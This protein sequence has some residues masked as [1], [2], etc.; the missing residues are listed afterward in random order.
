[1][2]VPLVL[3]GCRDSLPHDALAIPAQADWVDHGSI[4]ARGGLGEWDLLQWGGFGGTAVKKNGVYYLYYQGARGYRSPDDPGA[5][6]RTIGVATSHDGIH[7]RKHRDNPVL[8]WFPN[9]GPEEGAVSAAALVDGDEIVV[10]YGANTEAGSA[11]YVH[12][13]ARL[14]TSNDG[15]AFRDRG[16]VLRRQDAELWGSGDEISPIVAFKEEGRWVVY[17]LPNGVPESRRLGV[18]WGSGRSALTRSTG[19]RSGWFGDIPLWGMGGAARVAPGFF[20]LFLNDVT[21]GKI[22]VRTVAIST[23]HRLSDP[24]HI[25][26]F[27]EASQATV[28]LDEDRRT[29]FLY[30]R[31]R[32]GWGV[33]VAPLGER[34]TTPPTR[35]TRLA[36]SALDDAGLE[37]SWE[38]ASDG[39]TG[40]A[41][42]EVYRDGQQIASVGEA[43]FVDSGLP[44]LTEYHY[45]VAAVNLHGTVGDRSSSV[46]LRSPADRTPPVLQSATS[47]GSPRRVVLVFDEPL[48]P[49]TAESV[50]SYAVSDGIRVESAVL[51]A[52]VRTVVLSTA[53]LAEGRRY[54]ITVRGVGDRSRATN[55]ISIPRKR[56]F[57]H[58]AVPGLVGVWRFE[59]AGG[60]SSP[61]LASYG[62]NAR[63]TNP[64]SAGPRRVVGQMGAA[65]E[66]DGVA[67]HVTIEPR[68]PLVRTT[69]GSHALTATVLPAAPDPESPRA[70]DRQSIVTRA[71][72]GIFY[73][74]DATFEAR[75]A[76]RDGE[77]ASLRSGPAP[78]GRPYDVTMTVDHARKLLRLYVDAREVPGSPVSYVGRLGD[79]ESQPYYLGTSNP[80]PNLA[81]YRFRGEIAEI[82]VYE[83]A[84]EPRAP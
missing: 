5:S 57:V 12:A 28:L 29:W 66:F 75:L 39:D 81:D 38:P 44:E 51:G 10:Y 76:L 45:Q 36:G 33:K 82:R 64:L 70:A 73:G 63:W 32:D 42:Y 43:R 6:R 27:P 79:S 80:I 40:V 62:S 30:Y 9:D 77:F 55:R 25:Y 65:L 11:V 14:A 48:E 71:G 83:G 56:A 24:V 17:Y 15:F 23:P 13:D 84:I 53:E 68:G 50:D 31:A 26:R 4:F 37:L 52:D 74:P 72:S 46:R 22:E 35:P 18:A 78:P 7:F 54:E 67:N 16:A 20:A 8:S 21:Q 60:E 19:A 41:S 59:A 47:S 34:D 58:S 2:L 3:L 69:L 49:A 61:D 1:M